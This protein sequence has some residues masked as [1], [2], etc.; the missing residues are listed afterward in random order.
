V[1]E[2]MN[3]PF[4]NNVVP[5]YHL[6][7]NPQGTCQSLLEVGDPLNGVAYKLK[8]GN[9]V[10]HPQDI[11][12]FSWFARQSPSQGIHGLYTYRGTFSTYSSCQ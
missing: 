3:D 2:W 8:I 10:Y 12:F 1:G 7:F 6:P 9:N 4:N 11:A 5:A